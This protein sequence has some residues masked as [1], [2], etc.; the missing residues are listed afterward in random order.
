MS[1]FMMV[2]L[3]TLAGAALG[4]T[5][6]H[7][8]YA[9]TKPPAYV[10]AEVTVKD[11]ENYLKEFAP[12]RAKAIAD[13]GGKY[14]VRGG[15]ATAVRGTPPAGRIVVVQFENFDRAKAFT[16]SAGFKDSQVIGD[17][18]ADIRIYA[19]EGIAP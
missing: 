5:A 6:V 16:E 1:R 9:Q 2:G 3:S 11:Q 15:I 12:V 17:R 10:I 18:Y 4:G 13:S 8:T 14:L 19:V 7:T